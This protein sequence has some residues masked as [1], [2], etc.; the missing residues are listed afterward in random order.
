MTNSTLVYFERTVVGLSDPGTKHFPSKHRFEYNNQSIVAYGGMKDE[1]QREQIRG[2]GQDGGADIILLEEANQFDESDFNELI[3]RNRAKAAPWRQII[4]CTNPDAPTH[5]IYNRLILGGE[6]SVYYSSADQNIY[7]PADYLVN[8]NKLT[9][10]ERKRLL[11]GL[12]VQATGL[13]FDTWSDVPDGSGNVTEDAEYQEGAGPVYWFCDDGYAGEY[14]PATGYFKPRSH[15]RVFLFA[16]YRYDGTLCIFDELYRCKVLPEVQIEEALAKPYASPEYCAVDKSAATLKARLYQNGLNVRSG[17]GDV[18]ESIK[19]VQRWLTADA[20][21]RR[22]CLVHPRCR[23]HRLEMASYKR[24]DAT[25]KVVKDFDH[26]PDAKR[27]GIWCLR[28][29]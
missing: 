4:L 1:D 24:D 11:E 27:Y 23:H 15:P 10:I 25:G 5:W 28:Y 21:G 17:P 3:A 14:D 26:G 8:L 6:A 19:E 18:E 22:R 7:N 13:V 9:G 29:E 2:I 20:N 16:Q 12:W